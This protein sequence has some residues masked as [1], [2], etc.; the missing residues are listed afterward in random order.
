MQCSPPVA[1][2]AAPKEEVP[3]F[4]GPLDYIDLLRAERSKGHWAVL[5][6]KPS[7]VVQMSTDEGGQ[8]SFAVSFASVGEFHYA[9]SYRWEDMVHVEGVGDISSTFTRTPSH[10]ISRGVWVDA[11][12]HLNAKDLVL[13][14][15]QG[16]AAVYCA[17]EVYP[18]YLNIRTFRATAVK[19]VRSPFG[20]SC[21][22][23]P[24]ETLENSI[25]DVLVHA[26]FTEGG[27]GNEGACIDVLHMIECSVRG[28]M[29]QE[30]TFG[31]FPTAI[32]NVVGY[33]VYCVI[34][35]GGIGLPLACQGFK[36]RNLSILE[37]VQ[38]ALAGDDTSYCQRYSWKYDQ[39]TGLTLDQAR[40]LAREVHR[41][42]LSDNSRLWE[43]ACRNLSNVNFTVLE[44][45]VPA[46]FAV[47]SGGF[48]HGEPARI[49]GD[50]VLEICQRLALSIPV[51]IQWVNDFVLKV[52]P[53]S[54]GG[55]A[56]A[57]NGIFLLE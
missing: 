37:M 17:S 55:E 19:L 31:G 50:K 24:V 48:L 57:V 56:A 20:M 22:R 4:V 39:P 36:M 28:W 16:M 25:L 9:L 40:D 53:A 41:T 8:I 47:I 15:V 46:S 44:D 12:N 34:I 27:Y 29:W 32:D 35:T 26:G 18:L 7:H 45:C 11:I 49:T 52:P 38:A 3:I 23:V 2:K 42:V 5:T 33:L 51:T 43:S 13:E 30:L 1:C 14:V 10:V 21:T 54:L 6:D